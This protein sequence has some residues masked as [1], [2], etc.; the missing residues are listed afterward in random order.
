[1]SAAATGTRTYYRTAKGSH[2]HADWYCANGRRSIQLG[3]VIE[4][5]AAEVAEWAPCDVCTSAEEVKAHTVKVEARVAEMCTNT[6]VR[7][8]R[9]IQS[10][11]RDCGKRGTVNRS[12]GT[13]RAHKPQ[14]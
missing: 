8:P 4:I 3:D 13:L 12:T 6:G 14:R 9:C 1:M 2:R 7:N 10:E 5:P 11:C